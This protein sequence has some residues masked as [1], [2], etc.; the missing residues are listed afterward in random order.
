MSV[1]GLI[2]ACIFFMAGLLGTILPLLPGVVLIWLGM[3]FYGLLSGFKALT[4]EFYIIQAFIVVLVL[5]VDYIAQALGVKHF[6]GSK[7]SV[8]FAVVG[9]LAGLLLLGPLGVLIG[10][11]LLVLL[12]EL[13]QKKALQRA[14]H[15]ALGTLL[16]FLGGLL[17]KL[18]IEVFM[19]LWF[20]YT[21]WP[22]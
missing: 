22:G 5:F 4:L 7:G 18:L 3:L 10:P 16:G 15:T 11:F 21:I 17:A 12:W 19:I 9:F 13:T 20:F 6:G 2:A 1:P 8:L 14:L